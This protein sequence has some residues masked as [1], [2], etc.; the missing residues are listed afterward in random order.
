MPGNVLWTPFRQVHVLPEM[1]TIQSSA[2][3]VLGDLVGN[4]FWEEWAWCHRCSGMFCYQYGT[5]SCPA[6]G[7]GGHDRSGSAEL[8][9]GNGYALNMSAG[10]EGQQLGWRWCNKCHGLYYDNATTSG[11]CP[12]GGGHDSRPRLIGWNQAYGAEFLGSYGDVNGCFY[13]MMS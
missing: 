12:A 4:A 1:P 7:D 6:H 3:Y 9:Y 2:S 10:Y 13:I 5:G 8:D 11:W